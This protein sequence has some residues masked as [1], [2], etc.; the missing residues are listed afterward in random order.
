MD[1]KTRKIEFKAFEKIKD[2]Y[3]RYVITN[4]SLNYSENGILH[5]NIIDFLLSDEL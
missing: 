1:E 5:R 3:P 4:D 2:Y